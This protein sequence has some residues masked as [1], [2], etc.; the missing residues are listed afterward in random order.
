MIDR[1]FR[2]FLDLKWNRGGVAVSF[3]DILML[4]AMTGAAGVIRLVLM[5]G[6]T[7]WYGLADFGIA[8]AAGLCVL[9]LGREAGGKP[10]VTAALVCYGVFLIMPTLTV[11]SSYWQKP[12]GIYAL[13]C[14]GGVLAVLAGKPLAGALL[15][16]LGLV[17]NLQAVFLLPVF[18][19]F[20]AAGTLP[21]SGL[22]LSVAAGAVRLLLGVDAQRLLFGYGNEAAAPKV[23]EGIAGA[24]DMAQALGQ[25]DTLTAAG[26]QFLD[27]GAGT[28]SGLT[29]NVL[30]GA[31]GDALSGAAE[32][33]QE[34]AA[35][36]VQLLSDTWCNVYQLLGVT[37][38][39]VEYY[40]GGLCLTAALV[41]GCLYAAVYRGRA[42]RFR[43][44]AYVAELGLFFC[45]LVPYFAPHMNARSGLL[46]DLFAV[47]LVFF[48]KRK[49]YFAL[50][51]LVLSF[52]MYQVCLTGIAR[53]PL[54]FYALGQLAL[55]LLAAR[56]L[57]LCSWETEEAGQ[58]RKEAGLP[59]EHPG[60]GLLEE[61]P[62]GG[63]PGEPGFRPVLYR[64]FRLGRLELSLAQLGFLALATALG[65][66]MRAAFLP[67]V[68][69]DYTGYWELWFAEIDKYGG[70]RALAY[71]WYD[72]APLF[73]YFL[74]F[75]EGLPF[76]PMLTY[77][78]CMSVLDVAAAVM[79][80]KLVYEL[81]GSRNRGFFAYGF[82]FVL[83]TVAAN[84]ALW[85]QCD[86]T[87]TLLL[88]CCLYYFLKEKPLRAM[89][90]YSLAFAL[91]LQTLFV[92]PV[93][94]ILWVHKKVRVEHF[95][96]LPLAYV[97]S[98]IPAWLA[99]RP[100]GELLLVY[101][102][103]G[104]TDTWALTLSWPN[105]YEIITPEALLV[106]YS[107]LG[108]CLIIGIL[109]C[110]MYY[111]AKKP[112]RLTGGFLLQMFLFFGMLT[113]YFL[114]F[115]H[116]RYGYIVD[117]LAVVY[118]LAA[119]RRFYLPVLHVLIS[120]VSYTLF[121]TKGE[122]VPMIVYAFLLLALL[123][124]VGRDVYLHMDGK[125]GKLWDRARAG[126]TS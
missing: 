100:F 32:A 81:T 75:V 107:T 91:K 42:R 11:L 106:T 123:C 80:G 50:G 112:Y 109:I 46:A 22:L 19:L 103:Q 70:M 125:D 110:V 28:L 25:T 92:F 85:C 105:I 37:D 96:L 55:L 13:A 95:F 36:G 43:D 23:L 49:F 30:P 2:Y 87:Y 60:E 89:I 74:V 76:D 15:Y 1:F 124:A 26:R 101:L 14:F 121:L 86:V 68:S 12:E 72:Y 34:G 98:L 84:S 7:G 97:L 31:A 83:P 79:A 114:P 113:V 27:G 33:V 20:W 5:G 4:A 38:F 63:L 62:E 44:P 39:T 29:G 47:L 115:M 3:L 21:G 90:F 66:G 52:S 78:L 71:D 40:W 111:M 17:L 102:N 120:Y 35:R 99:G 6:F 53:F 10:P 65:I 16:G 64:S 9:R 8:L 48:C 61:R 94:V 58:G 24:A 82:V 59:G 45:M 119:P 117:I 73:M 88:L 67:Y 77:K 57:F 18:V 116:E 93:L 54:G 118:A 51:Q 56:D 122:A 108:K 104:Y 41:L 126:Q 69:Q